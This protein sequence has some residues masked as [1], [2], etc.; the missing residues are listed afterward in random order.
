[1]NGGHNG[2]GAPDSPPAGIHARGLPVGDLGVEA[3]GVV[4]D[5]MR[6]FLATQLEEALRRAHV[7][8]VLL[9]VFCRRAERSEHREDAALAEVRRLRSLLDTAEARCCLDGGCSHD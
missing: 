6:A 5:M 7:K 9:D 1:M 2:R 8:T 4:T 3:R